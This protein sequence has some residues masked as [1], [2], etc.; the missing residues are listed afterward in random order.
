V[1]NSSARVILTIEQSDRNDV[2]E[3]SYPEMSIYTGGSRV[4]D[5]CLLLKS[6]NRR[7]AQTSGVSYGGV[8]INNGRCE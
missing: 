7:D 5:Q 1:R 3:T 6:L 8:R 4:R 2:K